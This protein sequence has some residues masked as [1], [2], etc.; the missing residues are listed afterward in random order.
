[1]EASVKTDLT[2]QPGTSHGDGGQPIAAY[3]LGP[4]KMGLWLRRGERL[5]QT[6]CGLEQ[7]IAALVARAW[8]MWGQLATNPPATPPSEPTQ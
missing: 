4:A 8:R 3:P 2:S 5:G 7:A 1:M 6:V